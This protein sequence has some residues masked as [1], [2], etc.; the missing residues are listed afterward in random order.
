M[1]SISHQTTRLAS[2]AELT[3]QSEAG[4]YGSQD[5]RRYGGQRL[6][7]RAQPAG[8]GVFTGGATGN[9]L[10]CFHRRHKTSESAGS[11]AFGP[12]WLAGSVTGWI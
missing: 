4:R 9:F 12:C 10:Q 1:I 3:A 5:G 11:I 8:N 6:E 2:G 7:M